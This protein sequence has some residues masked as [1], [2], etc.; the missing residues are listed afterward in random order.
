MTNRKREDDSEEPSTFAS[1][2]ETSD[3]QE[4]GA[5][6][7]K[8]LRTFVDEKQEE[9]VYGPQRCSTDFECT[10]DDLREALQDTDILRSIKREYNSF[11]ERCSRTF[12]TDN[13]CYVFPSSQRRKQPQGLKYGEQVLPVKS[14]DWVELYDPP[15]VAFDN[16]LFATKNLNF[17]RLDSLCQ[18][19]DYFENVF[20]VL[21]GSYS[22]KP[23]AVSI[24]H[25]ASL[26]VNH[27]SAPY[28]L[29]LDN[30]I[31]SNDSD[32]LQDNP[33]QYLFPVVSEKEAN[34]EVV[35]VND[36]HLKTEVLLLRTTRPVAM[37]NQL[38]VAEPHSVPHITTER[39]YGRKLT[40]FHDVCVTDSV[41]L[42]IV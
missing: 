11:H 2:N 13:C 31:P 12:S 9:K 15:L 14:V 4:C 6:S 3:I 29:Q 8:K 7:T 36:A 28:Y 34:C 37:G 41:E 5:Q 10:V 24:C 35:S 26:C 39:G 22:S 40:W 19:V 20:A 17:R 18:P 27:T 23:S 16:M 38:C 33:F 25:L 21:Q 30:K 1:I 32:K 42:N